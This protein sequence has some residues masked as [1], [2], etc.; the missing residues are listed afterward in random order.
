[1]TP[2]VSTRLGA[3][4]SRRSWTAAAL[5]ASFAFFAARLFR[6][7]DRHAVD[8]LFRDQWAILAPEFEGKGLWA[9]VR[10][11]IGPVREGLGG[12][13]VHAVYALTGWNVRTDCFLTAGVLVLSA[14]IA[15]DVKRRLAGPLDVFDAALA[16]LFLGL[17][18]F[19]LF[20]VTPNPAH[21]AL[22]LLLAMGAAWALARDSWWLLALVG[23]LASH[24]G[25]ATYLAAVVAGLGVAVGI[26]DRSAPPLAAAAAIGA[27]LFVFFAGYHL[28]PALACFAFPH[29]RP[30][31]YLY[32]AGF[33]L[34]RP[35]GTF[36]T[37]GALAHALGAVSACAAVAAGAVALSGALRP[38][39]E[40]RA[41]RVA[42][43][44]I[45]FSLLF[46]GSVAVGRVCVGLDGALTS[47]YVPYALPFWFAIYLLLRGRPRAA[48]PQANLVAA[49]LLVAFVAKEVDPS[50]NLSTARSYSEPKRRWRECYLRLHDWRACDT[51][52]GFSID[53]SADVG[54]EFEFLR[55]NRLNV[56]RDRQ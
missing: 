24:T 53:F 18:T 47:R 13:W 21:G 32:F 36:P 6:L 5:V 33:F 27:A 10:V 50:V 26:R 31:E 30:S 35:F 1:L 43:L 3:A 48:S 17:A 46:A 49:A 20:A 19:E 34:A 55:Q 12:L 45:G 23:V 38:L 11:Q 52:T 39:E 44:L 28:N 22:P 16:P 29:P 9:M 8:I 40:A 7:V 51:E 15:L 4:A 25:F 14:A 56:Y 2:S 41:F 37:G 42:A 54:A